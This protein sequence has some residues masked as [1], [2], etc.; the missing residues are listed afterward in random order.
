MRD[1]EVIGY[2]ARVQLWKDGVVVGGAIMPCYFTE[3]CCKGKEGDAKHK[4]SMSA[5]QT[6][7]TSKAYRMNYSYIAIL[8]GYEPTPAEE[9]MGSTIVDGDRK[10]TEPGT[11]LKVCP[12]HNTK[13]YEG[14]FGLN[15]KTEDGWC[16][17]SV[18]FGKYF[19]QQCERYGWTKENNT[20]D[21]NDWLKDNFG[22]LTWSKMSDQQRLQ[23][24][25][26]M[27]G[28]ATEKGAHGS[29][30]SEALDMGAEIDE[31]EEA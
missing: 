29:L 26:L 20:G 22:G 17:A 24:I 11:W 19:G 4:A 27:R 21:I 23:A 10:A 1:N 30:V 16:K 2:Q 25:E 15:H 14:K 3:N 7:A 12:D 13:W 8:A 18:V 9:M 31:E 6:F 28:K 5:A